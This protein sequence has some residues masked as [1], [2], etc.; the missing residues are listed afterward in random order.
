MCIRDRCTK[1]IVPML[2]CQIPDQF[3]YRKT[4]R[5]L[6]FKISLEQSSD[7][8]LR[9]F[10]SSKSIL[11]CFSANLILWSGL[12]L[13]RFCCLHDCLA[14]AAGVL[15][16]LVSCCSLDLPSAFLPSI[17]SWVGRHVSEFCLVYKTSH[18]RACLC[19]LNTSSFVTLAT[20]SSGTVDLYLS[21]I[22][23]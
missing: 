23:I 2:V 11:V 6:D 4:F 22:H 8:M 16:S 5:T 19:L 20:H 13:F 10:C 1:I 9:E 21:L 7:F 17:V 14:R 12:K 18:R 3:Y 15:K